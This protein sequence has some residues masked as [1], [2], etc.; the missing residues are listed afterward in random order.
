MFTTVIQ[1]G[2]T[3]ASSQLG[4]KQTREIYSCQNTVVA[5]HAGSKHVLPVLYFQN[6]NQNFSCFSGEIN[7]HLIQDWV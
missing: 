7:R 6:L 3:L 2:P 4:L 1:Q 5:V